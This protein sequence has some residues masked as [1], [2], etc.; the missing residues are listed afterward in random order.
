MFLF[1]EQTERCSC[2]NRPGSEICDRSNR[3]VSF[4][5]I[6]QTANPGLFVCNEMSTLKNLYIGILTACVQSTVAV[7]NMTFFECHIG[8]PLLKIIY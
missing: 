2:I 4:L 3:G 8:F 6:S 1:E 7:S 5:R